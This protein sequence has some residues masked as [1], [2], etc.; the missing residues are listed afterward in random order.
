V[1]LFADSSQ[2]T[3]TLKNVEKKFQAFGSMVSGWGKGMLAAGAAI[4]APLLA[5]A[6]LTGSMGEE[7]G[8]MAKRTGVSVEALSGLAY[9]ASQ[10]G[11]SIE[12]VEGGMR[13]MQK[14]L[15]EAANGSK[16]ANEALETIG[17]SVD[18]LKGMKPDEQFVAISTAIGKIPS[19]AQRAAAAMEIFGKTGTE[20]LPMMSEGADG[21]NELMGR[22][23]ELG[24]V[25]ST[26][27]VEAAGAF[28]DKM[29]EMWQVVRAAGFA[30]GSTVLP[31]LTSLINIGENAVAF[32]TRWIKAH[33]EAVVWTLAIG[34]GLL[35]A[36]AAL[37]VFGTA[38]VW[39]VG[40]VG[41]IGT[42]LA[43]MW[44]FVTAIG[45]AIAT[46]LTSPL[47]IAI[48]VVAG[49]GAAFVWLSGAGG[50]ALSWLGEKFGQLKDMATEAFQGIAN[51]LLAGDIELAAKIVWTILKMA[52]ETGIHWL[53]GLWLSFKLGFVQTA[54]GMYFGA[55]A[56]FELLTHW[57]TIAWINTIAA[58]KTAWS[59]FSDW[60]HTTIESL[61]NWIAK[62][63]VDVQAIFDDTIDVKFQKDYIDADTK[64]AKGEIAAKRKQETDQIEAD[65]QSQLKGEKTEHEANMAAVGKAYQDE[66]DKAQAAYDKNKDG[67]QTKLNDLKAQYKALLEQAKNAR[68][69]TDK[70]LGG[71]SPPTSPDDFL[72]G[73]KSAS[74]A[75]GTFSAAAA[76]GMFGG[77]TQ[78]HIRRTAVATEQ[79]VK[80][81]KQPKPNQP[82]VVVN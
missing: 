29:D 48:G 71:T 60:Y 73:M 55:Q 35:A 21:I 53:E 16:Q 47:L 38:L 2:L 78:D 15:A 31:A 23:Q 40:L 33:K 79:L 72:P 25:L 12:T 26:K 4:T 27:D 43:T 76:Q 19:P 28:N 70:P 51:A 13:K 50:K 3:A 68:K 7:F 42:A 62:R 10:T 49:L 17:L 75:V 69:S 63:W 77:T 22:A 14:A 66:I 30:I 18:D 81:A 32:V 61:A 24:L 37:Y 67:D 74:K 57:L 11:T 64:N 39:A 41:A 65:R 56:A 9:V 58:L 59:A 54:Y 34:G 82:A 52:W 6:K 20:L 80:I 45:G 36:G 46:V 8:N 1:E 5:A 44:G